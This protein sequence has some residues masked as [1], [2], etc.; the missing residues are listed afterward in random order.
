M[1]MRFP[2]KLMPEQ[3][4]CYKESV[5]R[6][7]Y[8]SDLDQ[9]V[10]LLITLSCDYRIIGEHLISVGSMESTLNNTKIL[11]HRIIS[12]RATQFIIGHNHVNGRSSFSPQDLITAAQLKY[13]AAVLSVSFL[14][15]IIFPHNKEPVC[16]ADKHRKIWSYDYDKLVTLF[17]EEQILK[18]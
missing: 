12:D 11:L 15:S 14:D 6:M 3:I 16:L 8:I 18:L 1:S 7:K 9:E 10:L 2:P 13:M 17:I 4:T 5:D